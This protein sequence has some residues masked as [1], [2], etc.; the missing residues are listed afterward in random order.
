MNYWTA[1]KSNLF[2]NWTIIR[3]IKL[4]VGIS[5]TASYPKHEEYAL[6]FIG[7]YFLFLALLTRGCN[8]NDAC[9]I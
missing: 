8:Q 2:R 9:D 5:F 7:A 3:W 1:V 4:G 6:L